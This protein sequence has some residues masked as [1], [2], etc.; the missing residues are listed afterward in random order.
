MMDYLTR[1]LAYRY[2]TF[3]RFRTL[4]LVVAI[5]GTIFMY[6][7]I[8]RKTPRTQNIVTP[9]HS[10]EKHTPR[11]LEKPTQLKDH[12][13]PVT[14][15]DTVAVVGTDI[16]FTKL[17]GSKGAFDYL[18]IVPHASFK[19]YSLTDNKENID[20][21][22]RYSISRLVKFLSHRQDYDGASCIVSSNILP[23][24]NSCHF[25]IR[26]WTIIIGKARQPTS[27][28]KSRFVECNIIEHAFVIRRS[29]FETL[30]FNP[31]YGATTLLDFYL[32]SKGN[33]KLAAFDD[34]KFSSS[35]MRRDRGGLEESSFFTD[36]IYLGNNHN[37]VRIVRENEITW[38]K[39]TYSTK[40]CPEK[41]FNRTL[42]SRQHL[43]ICCSRVLSK[44]L[45]DVTEG[46]NNIG[47]GYRIVYGT[48]LGAVRSGTIIPWTKDIDIAL[49]E[50]D[51]FREK[52][53][54]R[55]EKLLK[56]KHYGV[57]V[58]KGQ[59]RVVPLFPP[60]Q[61]LTSSAFDPAFQ[62]RLFSRKML[63]VLKRLLLAKTRWQDLGY[64]DFY[65][66]KKEYFKTLATVKINGRSYS[67]FSDMKEMLTKWYGPNMNKPV[68]NQS[69][70][71]EIDIVKRRKQREK[72]RRSKRKRRGKRHAK[73]T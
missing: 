29:V 9:L 64:L 47:V 58:F 42:L 28:D 6:M 18:L 34:C 30:Y 32:R 21:Q 63:G 22:D 4:M 62:K 56:V 51:Y 14:N 41:P 36:Y 40:I 49:K 7:L 13:V 53:F 39:C 72:E 31:S 15:L 70:P 48:L 61:A 52:N 10:D 73:K 23:I 26:N 54:K 3:R 45:S 19:V 16:S 20:T 1:S 8:S 12:K 68:K 59:R 27:S 11:R 24:D 60:T 55:L 38:T 71:N 43:P 33:L 44:M 67:T 37:I 65:I 2:F 50:D 5:T 69:A 66:G 17:K 25:E 35:L 46:L 57:P